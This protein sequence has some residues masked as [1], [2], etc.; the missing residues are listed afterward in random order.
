MPKRGV[1]IDAIVADTTI[2]PGGIRYCFFFD[3]IG[4]NVDTAEPG[5]EAVGARN[6]A[7][8]RTSV[9]NNR[10]GTSSWEVMAPER[11]TRLVGAAGCEPKTPAVQQRSFPRP[12][13]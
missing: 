1:G 9:A 10:L 13:W 6:S 2:E 3:G 7:R 4:G 12:H 5:G 8:S 11:L